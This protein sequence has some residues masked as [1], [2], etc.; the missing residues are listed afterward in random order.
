MG[1]DNVFLL[2]AIGLATLF[3]VT[4]LTVTMI[5]HEPSKKRGGAGLSAT[6]E[7]LK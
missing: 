5:T 2:F 1:L 3:A 7:K 6:S 4:L